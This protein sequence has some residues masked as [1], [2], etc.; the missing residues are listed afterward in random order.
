M[1]TWNASSGRTEQGCSIR[2]GVATGAANGHCEAVTSADINNM[3]CKDTFLN[4]ASF[5]RFGATTSPGA[6]LGLRQGSLT[7]R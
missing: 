5:G 1:N 4:E 7:G 3:D 6:I 2:L